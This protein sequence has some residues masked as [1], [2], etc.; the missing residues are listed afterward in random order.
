M[1]ITD[2][3]MI[4]FWLSDETSIEPNKDVDYSKALSN[5]QE[6]IPVLKDKLHE[7]K[8]NGTGAKAMKLAIDIISMQEYQDAIAA[9]EYARYARKDAAEKKSKANDLLEKYITYN[10]DVS[11]L[12]KKNTFPADFDPND[13]YKYGQ[14][15]LRLNERF[16]GFS[17]IAEN[18]KNIIAE[19]LFFS[20]NNRD[21]S[22][23]IKEYSGA[24]IGNMVKIGEFEPGSREWLELRQTG[25]GASDV[26]TICAKHIQRFV[27]GSVVVEEKINKKTGEVTVNLPK[28]ENRRKSLES[29][30]ASKV[31]KIS[32]EQVEEQ[33]RGQVEF[34]DAS[35]RGNALEAFIAELYAHANNCVVLHNK[36]TWNRPG[37]LVNVNIDGLLTT[38]GKNPDGILEIKTATDPTNWG[39]TYLGI[40]GV[41]LNYRAQVLAATYEAGFDRGAVA[42]LIN[43][44]EFR[45]YNF[46]MTEELRQ[47]AESNYLFVSAVMENI[48]KIKKEALKNPQNAEDILAYDPV[49]Y[50]EKPLKGPRQKDPL[51]VF[52]KSMLTTG[53]TGDKGR[54]FTVIARYRGVD[55]EEVIEDYK[56]IDS[57]FIINKKT[58]DNINPSTLPAFIRSGDKEEWAKRKI[59]YNLVQLFYESDISDKTFTGVDIETNTLSGTMGRIIEIGITSMDMGN[60]KEE[61]SYSQLYNIPES[62]KRSYGTGSEDVHN[63]SLEDIEDKPYFDDEEEQKRILN[64][65]ME[66]K[67][68]FAHNSM[69]EKQFLRSQLKGFAQAEYDGDIYVMDTMDFI[70]RTMPTAKNDKL[71]EFCKNNAVEYVNA[72]RALQDAQMMMKALYNYQYMH[73]GEVI[74]EQ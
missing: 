50:G 12:I 70:K 47:E 58:I 2:N 57:E 25:A 67:I 49:I 37:S 21:N 40:D 62:S 11:E 10:Y 28:N 14:E 3:E 60:G 71:E 19:A 32:D 54:F 13:V 26:G 66:N 7:I 15:A 64:K 1:N 5:M 16:I 4:N 42:V 9:K 46:A 43:E 45:Y 22:T 33:T 56:E 53:L 74:F 44:T 24:K 8:E 51:T 38:D 59:I 27:D 35:S 69:F 18:Y 65:L 73:G 68:V 61:S 31:E 20:F 36:A 48:F 6:N 52:P 39:P 72:H 41:P 17:E 63:I 29:F 30:H 34:T 23:T 55:V